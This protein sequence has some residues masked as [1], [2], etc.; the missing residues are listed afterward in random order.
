MNYV[1]F[2]PAELSG[3]DYLSPEN[4]A[5]LRVPILGNNVQFRNFTPALNMGTLTISAGIGSVAIEVKEAEH[6]QVVDWLKTKG[7]DQ[8]E[9]EF[10]DEAVPAI[11]MKKDPSGLWTPDLRGRTLRPGL[12]DSFEQF[13]HMAVNT[14]VE[15]LL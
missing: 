10:F 15:K 5:H 7:S 1:T 8:R 13:V 9:G 12:E 3:L 14:A 2:A 11:V 6:F 4:V